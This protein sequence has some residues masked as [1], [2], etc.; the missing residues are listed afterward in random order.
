MLFYTHFLNK[1]ARPL[2]CSLRYLN[3]EIYQPGQIH[4]LIKINGNP[5][6]ETARLA[7]KLKLVTDTYILQAKSARFGNRESST[8][9]LLCEDADETAEH[10]ILTCRVLEPIRQSVIEAID[11]IC[12]NSYRTSF[13]SFDAR[14]RLQI[15]LDS[16][17]VHETYYKDLNSDHLSELEFESRRLC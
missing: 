3:T 12:N 10:F 6:R 9:C 14:D 8:Q 15:I 16:S 7:I 5:V 4:H 1:F 2:Y 17:K 11:S 13:F